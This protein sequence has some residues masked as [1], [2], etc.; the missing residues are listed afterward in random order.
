MRGLPAR[1]PR[2]RPHAN[3]AAWTVRI[4]FWRNRGQGNGRNSVHS[5]LTEELVL[6]YYSW[7][8]AW[9]LLMEPRA[10]K[11]RL[12]GYQLLIGHDDNRRN[13]ALRVAR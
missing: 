11:E 5:I 10:K 6:T 13:F 12:V 9:T 8:P 2:F 1:Y 3:L 4:E 7:P